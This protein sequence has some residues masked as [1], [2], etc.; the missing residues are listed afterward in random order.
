MPA[1]DRW[2]GGFLPLIATAT[3]T[4]AWAADRFGSDA[5]FAAL[6]YPIGVCAMTVVIGGLLIRETKGH[7]ID[8]PIG[9]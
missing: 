8:T 7:R 3:T 1:V 5:I 4:S 6:A 2:F 9:R